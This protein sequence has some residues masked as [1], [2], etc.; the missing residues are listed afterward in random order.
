M[1]LRYLT[2]ML[3]VANAAG[4]FLIAAG[5]GQVYDMSPE[6]GV[7]DEVQRANENAREIQDEQ[8]G[9]AESVVGPTITGIDAIDALL[10]A[11]FAA[12]ILLLNLGIPQFIVEFTFA[13]LYVAA[14]IDIA[15]MIRGMRS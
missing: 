9:A 8:L 3:V 5:A 10:S 15:F 11:P 14:S 4:G 6:P 12:P 2:I 1:I 13:P 7:D